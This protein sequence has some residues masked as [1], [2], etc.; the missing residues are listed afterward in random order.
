MDQLPVE[1]LVNVIWKYL[2]PV[3]IFR[4]ARYTNKLWYHNIIRSINTIDLTNS[5]RSFP[6]PVTT[7]CAGS[8]LESK[9]LTSLDPKQISRIKISTIAYSGAHAFVDEICSHFQHLTSLDVLFSSLRENPWTSD[10][11]LVRHTN[12]RDLSFDC[13]EWPFNDEA[14]EILLPKLVSFTITY[15]ADDFVWRHAAKMTRLRA[16]NVQSGSSYLIS[17]VLKHLSTLE[18]L[19]FY[20]SAE[21]DVSYLP[22][23]LVSLDYSPYFEKPEFPNIVVCAA[24]LRHLNI[25]GVHTKIRPDQ[26]PANLRLTSLEIV[27][28]YSDILKD[29][30]PALS[31]LQRLLVHFPSTQRAYSHLDQLTSVVSLTVKNP[32]AHSGI[33]L[34]NFP[35]VQELVARREGNVDKVQ[36]SPFPNLATTPF[37]RTLKLLSFH[38]KSK[39]IEELRGLPHLEELRIIAFT[40]F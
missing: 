6:G 35:H 13:L 29:L 25:G 40:P 3:D 2:S 26:V 15:D 21:D 32:T 38:I 27:D 34:S 24:N 22:P 20:A 18:R 1:L 37:L 12:L 9:Y 39:M 14:T 31:G 19:I 17:G 7:M 5:W 23:N 11:A 4:R 36:L 8:W 16:L 30:S 33:N 28:C 10:H